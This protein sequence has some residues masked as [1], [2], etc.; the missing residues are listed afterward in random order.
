[1]MV[2]LHFLFP[3]A[4]V[5]HSP[6]NYLGIL[7]LLTG[8]W[9]NLAADSSFKRYTTTVKPFEVSSRLVTDGV[10]RICR[11]PMYLGFVLI[12]SGIAVLMGSLAPFAV[13]PLFAFLIDRLFIQVEESM[14]AARFGSSW[15]QYRRDVRRWI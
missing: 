15:S 14:L 8:V 10:Y 2:C 7:L 5:I 3:V 4:K 11:H 12:L 1:M 13:I 9:L 6:W